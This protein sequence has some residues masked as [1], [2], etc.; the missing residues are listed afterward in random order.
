MTEGLE[1]KLGI[2]RLVTKLFDDTFNYL[3]ARLREVYMNMDTPAKKTLLAQLSEAGGIEF[4]TMGTTKAPDHPYNPQ[5]AIKTR[6]KENLS[7]RGLAMQ[8][9]Y[10]K[11]D[12]IHYVENVIGSFENVYRKPSPKSKNEVVKRYLGWLKEHG[13]NPFNLA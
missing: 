12:R 10:T 13:Y 3:I 6:I 2:E 4:P 5:T 9:G 7:R 8:L 11:S 1:D